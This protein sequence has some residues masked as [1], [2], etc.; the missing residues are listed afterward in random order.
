LSWPGTVIR[1][2]D[3]FGGLLK[4]PAT[5]QEVFDVLQR[6]RIAQITVP[7]FVV[8]LRDIFAVAEFV[9]INERIAAFR[10]PKDDKVLELAFNGRADVIVSGDAD[11]LVMDGF[12]G[13]P[14][15]TPAAFVNAIAT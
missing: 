14:I 8:R 7:L 6:P 5:E 11:L 1:W 2:L 9:A 13:I 4:T 3:S 12:R 10:D 15:L